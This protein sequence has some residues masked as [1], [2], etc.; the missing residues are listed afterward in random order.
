LGLFTVIFHPDAEKEYTQLV[1]DYP[2]LEELAARCVQELDDFPP[3]KWVDVHRARFENAFKSDMHLMF[4]IQGKVDET[5]KIV[6]ITRFR[7][8]RPRP[9]L[10]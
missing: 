1:N 8:R 10:K 4:D 9:K 6:V 3:E 2:E 7:T 5:K